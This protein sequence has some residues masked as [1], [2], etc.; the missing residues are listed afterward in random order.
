LEGNISLFHQPGQLE[1]LS[2]MLRAGAFK[3]E[4]LATLDIKAPIRI[5]KSFAGDTDK[6]YHIPCIEMAADLQE[7]LDAE[8]K[9]D[10]D[11]R[12]I[13]RLIA[14]VERSAQRFIVERAAR[15]K[16]A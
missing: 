2:D 1:G 6:P 9:L 7:T 14:E 11:V 5:P 10:R 12:N 3:P 8:S 4:Y 16:T 13:D 15:I